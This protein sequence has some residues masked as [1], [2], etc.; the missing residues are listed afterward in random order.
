MNE[1]ISECWNFGSSVWETNSP[2]MELRYEG[3]N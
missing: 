2:S 1:E 3:R